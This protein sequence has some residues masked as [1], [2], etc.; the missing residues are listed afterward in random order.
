MTD[1]ESEAYAGMPRLVP[2]DLSAAA[3]GADA[4]EGTRAEQVLRDSE[5]FYRQ[6]LES[7]PGMVFTTRPDGY[8]DYQSQQWVDYTGIPM[9]Q[10]L[11]SGWNLLLHP[12]DRPAAF[13]AWTAA[14]QGRA[15]YNL[16]YRVRRRDGA[17]EWFKVIGRPIRDSAG[18]VVR[19][20]GVAANID[21][22][23]RAEAAQR[24]TE[25]TLKVALQ[26]AEMGT[27]IYTFADDVCVFSEAAQRLYGLAQ[28]RFRHDEKNVRGLF[29]E[30]DVPR[31]WQAIAEACDPAGAGRYRIEYRVRCPELAGGWRWLNAWG[32]V[33]WDRADGPRRAVRM[34]GA[35]C[36]V[37]SRKLAEQQLAEELEIA[38]QLQEISGQLAGADN[39]QTLHGRI[40]DTA[41]AVL[42]ADFGSLQVLH[43]NRG[44]AGELELLEHR[45]FDPASAQFWRWVSPRSRSACG[46][47]LQTGDRV[48]VPDVRQCDWLAGSEDLA[49]FE[50]AGIRAVQTTPLMS[51]TGQVLGMI[52]THWRQPRQPALA[53]L[54][55]ID[56]LARQAADLIERKK[57]EDALRR[58]AEEIER[59][60]EAAPA[61]VWVAHDPAC[62]VITGNRRANE[63]YEADEG[64]NVSASTVRG[65]RRFFSADGRELTPE[66]LPMQVAAATNQPVHGFEL[67]VLLASGARIVLLGTAVPLR[68]EAGQVRGCIGA[69]IDITGRKQAEDAVRHAMDA[70]EQASRAKD[71]FIAVLSHE[72][73]TPLTPVLVNVD[74]LEKD[75]ALPPQ[76]RPMIETIRRN[77]ELE[78]RLIDDLLDLTRIA[79]NKLDLQ[80]TSVDV[81]EAVGQVVQMCAEDIGLKQIT[82]TVTLDALHH[83]VQADPARL[84]QVLWNVLKNAVKFTPV[85]G[86]ITL[87]SRDD[88]TGWVRL[89][90][91]DNG[92]GIAPE[93]LPRVFE[94]FEQGGRE[95]TRQFGGLGLGLAIS[96]ALVEMH[97]G[98]IAAASGGKGRGATFTIR[99]PASERQ[100]P[101]RKG[102]RSKQTDRLDASLLLVEDH[103]D[104][105][106]SMAFLLRKLGCKVQ[107]A[108]TVAEAS[109]FAAAEKFDLMISDIGL[110]DG[111]GAELMRY[112]KDNYGLRGI[113]LSGYGMEDDQVRSANAGFAAHL[114]KPVRLDKLNETI[115]RV[116]R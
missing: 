40:L 29:H 76:H 37:T 35:S 33:E 52:S 56:V 24:E 103:V 69:F 59:L 107:E 54:R 104:T 92:V 68:D 111:S 50:R 97:G 48:F 45:G 58:R 55:A 71:Q 5:S 17:Y 79:R 26:A 25:Q 51:R 18:N 4:S 44:D 115:R 27:W 19:W 90:V 88:A 46:K 8:C 105:R 110:P 64:A 1:V 91:V 2:R 106:R 65:V 7:I 62:E 20:F 94:A 70:A 86:H 13:A 72:L 47:A 80:I 95:V 67:H 21:E 82:L 9:D 34:I 15:P 84:Q 38:R 114:T 28:A 3:A 39:I 14:V 102:V 81:H 49:C 43:P 112:V 23:K 73:R 98:T 66:E 12:D 74:L 93:A 85:C 75:E 83:Q 101:G 96:K 60:M 116:L 41:I 16:E 11:G 36:D 78:A 108:G 99:L 30:D 57:N 113:A 61:A 10:H 42:R 100:S 63:I 6:T 22:L 87:R 31:M 77:V 109:A 89:E 32:T 53:Q